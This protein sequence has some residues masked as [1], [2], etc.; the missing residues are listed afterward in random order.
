MIKNIKNLILFVITLY[1][2]GCSSFG[3]NQKLTQEDMES[4][5]Q[6]EQDV[7][8]SETKNDKTIF[9]KLALPEQKKESVI[10]NKI[11]V[12]IFLPLSG[13][14]S[15]VGSK[16]LNAIHL[17]YKKV[18]NKN[19]VLKIYDTQ[20]NAT[21]LEKEARN[22]IDNNKI[23]VVVGPIFSDEVNA[24]SNALKNKNIPILSLSNNTSVLKEDSNV[25]TLS[26]LPNIDLERSINFAI[27]DKQSKKFAILAPQNAYGDLVVSYS[28]QLLSAYGF[29]KE[30]I[31]IVRYE[32]N[33]INLSQ[34][35][36]QLVPKENLS[37]YIKLQ[38]KYLE[39][40]KT[41]IT[42]SPEELLELENLP[43]LEF[44]TL[45]IGDFGKRLNI[46]ASHFASGYINY[47][48]ITILGNSNWMDSQTLND[49]VLKKSFY[50]YYG[51]I[52]NTSYGDL[53]FNYY[54]YYPT[55]LEISGA[56]SLIIISSLFY[57]DFEGNAL[58]DISRKNIIST[59]YQGVL[60]GFKFREDG[61]IVRDMAMFEVAGKNIK[62][63]IPSTKY[64]DFIISKGYRLDYQLEPIDKLNITD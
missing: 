44:D 22:F 9:P 52:Q 24:I 59:G 18:N 2:V 46:V 7:V 14:N 64:Q 43:Q 29:N 12:A 27:K 63:I 13:K 50:P 15:D 17:S 57:K 51:D 10:K 58:I 19:I 49:N 33:K 56:E 62:Q 28:T 16:V 42:L 55:L 54:N 36:E 21:M 48:E 4:T 47:R 6:E 31:K 8:V 20:S 41:K 26:F 32:S 3:G 60:G 39:S 11:N 25:Y 1:L 5:Q 45:I 40:K 30:E 53:F 23:D 34:N 38:E 37:R 35:I 61:S